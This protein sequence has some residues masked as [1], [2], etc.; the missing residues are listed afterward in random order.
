MRMNYAVRMC[1]SVA[2]LAAVLGGNTNVARAQAAPQEKPPI[3][4]WVTLW[5]FPRASW[6]DYT[7][8][9]AATSKT[10]ENF[11]SSGDLVSTASFATLVHEEG[12][13]T[14]G[15]FWTSKTLA[16]DLKVLE[17]SAQRSPE[18][19]ASPLGCAALG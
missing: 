9:V 19:I 8:A 12:G 4:T 5:G 3:Y 10:L 1:L 14:H 18:H 15:R 11:V 16:G 17:G 2:G 13:I 7:K 6:P